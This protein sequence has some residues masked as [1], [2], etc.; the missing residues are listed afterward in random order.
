MKRLSVF[1]DLEVYGNL[2]ENVSLKPINKIGDI[3]RLG[4]L[5]ISSAHKKISNV[6]KDKS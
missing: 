2:H 4:K 6:N 3:P 5:W 1:D